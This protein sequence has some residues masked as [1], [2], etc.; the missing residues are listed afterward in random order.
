MFESTVTT[1]SSNK[2]DPADA[3]DDRLTLTSRSRAA[4]IGFHSA[5]IPA[6]GES[7]E[8]SHP[9]MTSRILPE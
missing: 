6:I 9:G 2:R 3:V 1:K 5:A 7:G 8:S 4:C